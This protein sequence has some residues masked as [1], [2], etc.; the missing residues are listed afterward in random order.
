MTVP[1]S[2]NAS[3][4]IVVSL[5]ILVAVYWAGARWGKRQPVEVGAGSP[6]TPISALDTSVRD[7]SLTADEVTN[8]RVYRQ[9]SPAVA[10]ILTKAI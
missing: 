8:V 2:P 7:A 1:R 4:L 10:N 3:R 5:L 6:T 9:A